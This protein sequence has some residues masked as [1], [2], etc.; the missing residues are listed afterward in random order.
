[1]EFSKNRNVLII[2]LKSLLRIIIYLKK[3]GGPLKQL[4]LGHVLLLLT[5]FTVEKIL[6][7]TQ[8][9]QTSQRYH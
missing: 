7:I 4:E 6:A 8:T 5:L 2:F 1:M 3:Q 9:L